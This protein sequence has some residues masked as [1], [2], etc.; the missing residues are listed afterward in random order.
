MT[1]LCSFSTL[2][3]WFTDK[4]DPDLKGW[5]MFSDVELYKLHCRSFS[6]GVRNNLQKMCHFWKWRRMEQQDLEEASLGIFVKENPRNSGLLWRIAKCSMSGFFLFFFLSC[7]FH[8]FTCKS[9]II[10]TENLL[11]CHHILKS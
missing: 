10:P 8:H 6:M 1:V 3:Y 2:I 7:I 11:L 5:N 9:I 4:N